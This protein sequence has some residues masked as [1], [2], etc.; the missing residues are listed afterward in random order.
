MI[1][2]AWILGIGT[3]GVW[4]AGIANL[5]RLTNKRVREDTAP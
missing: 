4:I 5:I 2:L 3:V 1:V